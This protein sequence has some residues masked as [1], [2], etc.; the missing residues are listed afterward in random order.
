MLKTQSGSHAF[1][2]LFKVQSSPRATQIRGVLRSC[3]S[4][5]TLQ[6]FPCADPEGGQ[7]PDLPS[8]PGK[9]QNVGFL[10]NTGLDPLKITKPPSQHLMLGHHRHAS[11]TPFKWRLAG[12]SMMA[13]L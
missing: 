9:S 6:C 5:R 13:R 1:E 2:L 3:S 8:P 12:G 7:V 4:L 11:E 10:C